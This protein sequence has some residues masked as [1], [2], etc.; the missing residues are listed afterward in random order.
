MIV[1][2]RTKQL[3]EDNGVELSKATISVGDEVTLVYSGLLAKSG[4]DSIYAHIGYGENWDGKEY[5]PMEKMED[6][7]KATIKVNLSD[8]LNIAFRDS[9]D[10]WDNNSQQ[11]YSFNVSTKASKTSSVSTESKTST[12]V[13]ASAVKSDAAKE[14]SETKPKTAK[15]KSTTSTKSAAKK[16]TTADKTLTAK[17]SSAT[18]SAAKK[19]NK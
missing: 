14:V 17:K 6:V 7:F 19:T 12:K 16:T 2:A 4:A 8:K 5:I 18:K 9:V 11:N 3:Y 15:A 10:N 13:K 1:L